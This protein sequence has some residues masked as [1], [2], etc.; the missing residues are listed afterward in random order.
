M[1]FPATWV[2]ESRFYRNERMKKR[3]AYLTPR[4]CGTTMQHIKRESRQY[5]SFLD[6]RALFSPTLRPSFSEQ[7]EKKSTKK[8]NYSRES[9]II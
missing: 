4:V 8:K 5:L 1:G 6:E 2:G 3:P 7:G 9:F